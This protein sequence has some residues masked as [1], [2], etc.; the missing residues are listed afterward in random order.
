M[1]SFSLIFTV[2]LAAGCGDE[3]GAKE[4]EGAPPGPPDTTA[5]TSTGSPTTTV[6]G[7]TGAEPAEP[8]CEADG[9]SVTCLSL[10]HI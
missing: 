1:R 8:C 6:P 7:T 9:D 2:L 5:G 4:T 3:G 10:I